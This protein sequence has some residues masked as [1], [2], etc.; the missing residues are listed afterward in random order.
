MN[1]ITLLFKDLID[2][3]CH[4]YPDVSID[5]PQTF[6]NEE[7]VDQCHD[8]GMLGLVLKTHG[9][10]QPAVAN[11]LNN[12][13]EDFYV[14]PSATLNVG[15]GGPYPWTVDMA[16]SMGCRY[17]W[18][19]TWGA[20]NDYRIGNGGMMLE[21]RNYIPK[22]KEMD[23]SLFCRLTDENGELNDNI[24]ECIELAKEFDLIMGTGHAGNE[25]ALVALRYA[26]K[27]G[28]KKMVF[29]HP[30]GGLDD[31]TYAQLKEA[32]DL[33]AYI[34]VTCLSMLPRYQAITVQTLKEVIDTCG[35][36]HVYL[37]SDYF[38]DN[39]P[40]VPMQFEMIFGGL[41]SLGTKYEDLQ[42][43]VEIPRKL[44]DI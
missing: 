42:K 40:P 2:M 36:D 35:A 38:F 22:M 32:A 9:W 6:S 34:E 20:Y 10:P 27:I 23:E 15:S 19:P 37:S 29:T 5:H 12:R 8:A 44:L 18:L 21:N 11:M 1:K 26:N 30:C 39:T 13:Y 41:Y 16:R 7:L 3:H 28:Y 31:F 17:V 43:M 33:G 4:I 24:K 14:I 25:E